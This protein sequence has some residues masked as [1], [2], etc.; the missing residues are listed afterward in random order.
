MKL[1]SQ[2][3]E[4]ENKIWQQTR[5]AEYLNNLAVIQLMLTSVE[6]DDII[7]QV[8]QNPRYEDWQRVIVSSDKDFL[9]LCDGNTVLFRPI[10]KEV[11]NSNDIVK[12]YKIHPNNFA[13]ARA[14]VGDKSDNLQGVGGVGLATVA[15]RFPFLVE[16]K[17]YTCLL[18]TSPS[19]RD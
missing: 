9:Q 14:I 1:I 6:A 16:E 10:Q 18:Y 15:K 3:K 11:L 12:K 13:L 17:S 8:V 5:L 19:P 2:I 4:I 7:A